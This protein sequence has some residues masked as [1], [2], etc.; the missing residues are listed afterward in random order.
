MSTKRNIV[1][2]CKGVSDK[3]FIFDV[4]SDKGFVADATGFFKSQNTIKADQE[5]GAVDKETPLD[6]D[7]CQRFF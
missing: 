1:C 5:S 7:D 2:L 3:D 4:F 6:T